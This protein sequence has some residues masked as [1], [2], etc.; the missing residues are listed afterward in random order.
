MRM[1]LIGLCLLTLP[2]LASEPIQFRND[3]EGKSFYSRSSDKRAME[4]AIK[5]VYGAEILT[6]F[7]Q[8]ID[9]TDE[10]K[11]CSFDIN[12][13]LQKKLKSYNKK[14][15]EMEG[16]IVYLRSQN[17]IDDSVA[18]ILLT[19]NKVVTTDVKLPKEQLYYPNDKVMASSLEVI[20]NFEKKSKNLCFD[21][22]YKGLYS[23]LIR[24]DKKMDSSNVEAVLVEAYNKKLISFDL[25]L[26]LEQSRTSALEQSGLTLKAYYKKIRSLRL[27]YPLRDSKEQSDFITEKLDKNDISRRQRLLESYSDLQIVMMANIVKKLRTRLE[28]PK[29]EI[30]IYD[31]SNG[32]E[33]IAL[34]PMER[35]RLAIKL[36]RKEM[37]LL[38]LNTYFA[39]RTPDYMD[40]MTASY[41][42][43]VIPASELK[44]VAGL[45]DV[46]NP[47]KTFWEK[48]DVWIRTLS[49]VAT[50]AVPPPYG[51]VPALA[52]VV[53]EMTAG[54]NNNKK[55]DP[56]VLF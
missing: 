14:F 10:N 54:K 42:V 15:T 2:A 49:T 33:T 41:E 32:V 55:D 46:W 26:K 13:E 35:F 21:E 22:A 11:L 30:L 36:L 29:V 17:E 19:A 45:Q 31:R 50:V 52:L 7:D 44:E 25:Y 48:A 51:F 23:D 9:Q 34:D 8:I 16:V 56:T 39:G 43:G 20:K 4:R 53:I 6:S 1:S 47:Q 40:L 38:A 28:S 3:R 5:Q 37:S 18:K 24:Q 27:Q 12:Y